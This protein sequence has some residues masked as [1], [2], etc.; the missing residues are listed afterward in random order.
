ML[1]RTVKDVFFFLLRKV[2]LEYFKLISRASNL[3]KIIGSCRFLKIVMKSC[4]LWFIFLSIKGR[5]Q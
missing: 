2:T 3:A 1:G 5:R 4:A